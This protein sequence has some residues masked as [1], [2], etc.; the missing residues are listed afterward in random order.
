MEAP[1]KIEG[2]ILK[3]GGVPPI[4]PHLHVGEHIGN[5]NGT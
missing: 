1:P 4:W 5:L 3:Y 2:F